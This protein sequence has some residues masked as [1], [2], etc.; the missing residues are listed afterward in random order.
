MYALDKILQSVDVD[1]LLEHFGFEVSNTEGSI[2]RGK[3]KIHGGN[4]PTS[5][6]M[7]RETTMWFCHTG[8]CG[9]GDA[10]ELVQKLLHI[11]FFESVEWLSKF[12]EV[13]ITG[14]EILERKDKLKKE[15]DIFIK[16]MKGKKTKIINEYVISEEIKSVKSFRK[17]KKETLEH[18]KLG[19]VD[20]ITL[21]KRSDEEYTLR[22]RLLFPIIFQGKTV[23]IALRRTKNS[24]VPKWSNQPINIDTGEML[25]NYDATIGENIIVIVEG[26]TDVWAYHEIGITAI[27]TFGAHLTDK[28]YKLIIKTGADVVLSYDN[29]V[30]GNKARDKA[31]KMLKNKCNLYSVT[32]P[33]GHDAEDIER[34]E[35]K[36]L[37][38]NRKK[39]WHL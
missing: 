8:G 25:Y 13:D 30:A 17:F 28:Q 3:C 21:K 16:A 2:L 14:L 37:Y 7:N 12:F 24:D 26:I 34:G 36:E 32:L 31:I 23:G 27:A 29:D 39:M 4:N 18:F 10:F 9:G 5:F 6:V 33:E 38:D 22:N 15:L 1:K 35:L 20:K 11:T 19:Y